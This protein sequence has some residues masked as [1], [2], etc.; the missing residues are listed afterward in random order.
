MKICDISLKKLVPK[1][2]QAIWK[3]AEHKG[4]KIAENGHGIS[5]YI[6]A[7]VIACMILA[8]LFLIKVRLFC[9]LR[10][11]VMSYMFVSS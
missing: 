5:L 8:E 3:E 9:S 2:K 11:F 1:L 6:R 10:L 7:V 4:L